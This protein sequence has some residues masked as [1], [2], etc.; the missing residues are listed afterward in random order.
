MSVPDLGLVAV[1]VKVV[2]LESF[3]AAASAL[4]L[5][6]SSVS[7]SVSQ[8][9]EGLGVRLL[10]R[11]SR[12][13]SLTD[14]GRGFYDRV[15]EPLHGV[16]DALD[17]AAESSRSPSGVIRMSAPPD[18]GGTLL[19]APIAEF[20]RK[21]PDIKIDLVLTGRMVDLVS[22]RFDLAVRATERLEDSSLVARRI[23][24]PALG[25][26][27]SASYVKRRG[28]PK[29]V[30]E[31]SAHDCVLFRAHDTR[32]TWRLDGPSGEER[33]DVTGPINADDMGFIR[34][35]VAEGL[36][37]GLLPS[38]FDKDLVRILPEHTLRAGSLHLVMPSGRHVPAR[39]SLLRDFLLEKLKSACSE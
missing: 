7:R 13:L 15:R 9:E 23:G 25:L 12:H 19:A 17:T 6:K 20:L 11:T 16:V 39:V 33:V 31:L 4:G 21:Y 37:I 36:G 26:Y 5:P 3:T 32:A 14:A 18:M 29:T 38:I 2:E 27:A 35:M 22:E 1:F 24:G 8:L 10:Q 34:R 28:K 30:A